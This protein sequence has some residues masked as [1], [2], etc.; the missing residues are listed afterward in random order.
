MNPPPTREWYCNCTK[1]CKNPPKKV[2]HATYK[3]H[4][5]YRHSDQLLP[6][7]AA[8]LNV[9]VNIHNQ[10][11]KTK[12]A[13]EKFAYA[14]R[15]QKRVCKGKEKDSV[16]LP[17]SEQDQSMLIDDVSNLSDRVLYLFTL[18]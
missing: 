18:I 8:H 15:P 4:A 9:A 11:R 1:H 2:S 6:E 5:P 17:D 3:R 10:K 16:P 14:G 13:S 12:R 7:V